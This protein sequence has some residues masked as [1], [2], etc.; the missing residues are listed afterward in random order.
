M[1]YMMGDQGTGVQFLAEA[2]G[3]RLGLGPTQ[4]TTKHVRGVKQLEHK[5]DHLH[6]TRRLKKRD[7]HRHCPIRLHGVIIN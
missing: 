7:E 5:V 2:R 6:L 1:G 4:P 3:S